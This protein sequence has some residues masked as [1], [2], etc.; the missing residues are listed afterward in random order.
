MPRIRYLKPEFFTDE[1]LA[2]LKFETRL[3]F[4]GLWCY[5]DK[6][7]RLEDRP[8]YLKAMI[9]P[10]DNIDIEKQLSILSEPK[11]GNG[12]PFVIRY[13]IEGKKYIQ[14]LSWDKH[15]KPH[16]TEADSKIPPGPPLIIKGMEKGMEKQEEA[17]PPTNNGEKPVRE[18]LKREVI[19]IFGEFQNVKLMENQYQ[20]LIKKFGESGAKDR[21][22]NLSEALASKKGYQG[23][24][25]D[26]YATILSWERKNPPKLET[27]PTDKT[28]RL[29]YEMKKER[30][31][32][33]HSESTQK[34][35]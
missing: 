13:K 14:I 28:Q 6:A 5:A 22:E 4:A 29:I 10:Y 23:K 27:V 35:Y 3:A 17:N 1:D 2:E 20:K 30:E 26:H 24:Y 7:G 9:F 8:K 21:I 12:T 18:P 31:K 25:V 19:K 34:L 11:H 32:D 15:Q 16:H 33:G